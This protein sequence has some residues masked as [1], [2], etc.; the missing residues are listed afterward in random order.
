MIEEIN[1][2]ELMSKKHKKI[3]GILNYFD[4]SLILIST[5]T[6][7]VSISAFASLVGIPIEIRSSATGLKMYKSIIKKKKKYDKIVLLAKSKLNSIEVLISEALIDSNINHNEFILI[8]NVLNEFKW[9]ERRN[10]KF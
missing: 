10:Q 4:H 5:I 1:R 2:N 9:Y 8:N 6:G 7:Y 3:C